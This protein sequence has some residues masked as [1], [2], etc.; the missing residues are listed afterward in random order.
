MSEKEDFEK[1]IK[2]IEEDFSGKVGVALKVLDED[3]E[4]K[5]GYNEKSRFPT[6]SVIKVPVLVEAFKQVEEGKLNLS[7]EYTLDQGEKVGGSGI[8]K[9][10]SSGTS[11]QL[12]DLLKLMIVISDN[13]ATNKVLDIIGVDSVNERL[14]KW[15]LKDIHSAG[16][17]MMDNDEEDEESSNGDGYSWA[18]PEGL[19]QLLIMLYR[20]DM[21]SKKESDKAIE[22]LEHQQFVTNMIGRYLPYDPEKDVDESDIRIA[23]KSGS[24]RGV[25][26]D[27]GFIWYDDLIY[28]VALMTKNCDD[29][30]FY[31]DNEGCLT[32]AELSKEIFDLLSG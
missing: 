29:E 19:L 1:T 12:I 11:F 30:R 13:T 9:E 32:V 3:E 10:I 8:L 16:K 14:K 5:F 20:G 4:I 22:I 17:L 26:N 2:K 15:G 24:I 18:T 7:K 25:R 28:A 31:P 6:A 21:L 23:S 27:I